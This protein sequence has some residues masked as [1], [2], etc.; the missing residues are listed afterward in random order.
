MAA[1]RL[2]RALCAAALMLACIAG[3]AIPRHAFAQ[4]AHQHTQSMWVTVRR[5]EGIPDAGKAARLVGDTWIP[6]ISKIPGFIEYFWVDAGNGVMVS[7][8]VFQTKA[9]EEESNT[10]VKQ[11]RLSNPE[12]IAAL[13]NPPQITAG[14]VVAYKES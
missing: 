11:W 12:A 3:V 2:I 1:R 9:G 7:T 4:A 10:K 13:P 6:I 14:K 5:Y 8:S